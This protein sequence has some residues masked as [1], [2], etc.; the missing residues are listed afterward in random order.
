MLCLCL[1]E[2]VSVKVLGVIIQDNWKWNQHV[3]ATVKKKNG[4]EN[5]FNA[6]KAR[7]CSS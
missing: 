1:Q 7:S 2:T 6:T 4:K 5:I 3:D